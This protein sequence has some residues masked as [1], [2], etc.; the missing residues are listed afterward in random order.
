MQQLFSGRSGTSRI[1]ASGNRVYMCVWLNICMYTQ[2]SPFAI[3]P[4]TH[5]NLIGLCYLPARFF[6]HLTLDALSLPQWGIR[7]AFQRC[8]FYINFSFF[9]FSFCLSPDP[10]LLTHC[11]YRVLLLQLITL[12]DTH[13]HTHTHTRRH[14]HTHSVGLPW[15]RDQPVAD[16]STWQHTTLRTDRY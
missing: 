13:T 11:R 3:K 12:N 10:F 9:L 5:W 16:V 1:C 4:P 8:Y 14:T 6:C 7:W 2:G 15:K